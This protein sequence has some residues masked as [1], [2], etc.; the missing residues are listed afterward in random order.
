MPEPNRKLFRKE[1][2]ER[3]SSPDNLERLMPVA[4]ALDWLVI[5]VTGFLLACVVVWSIVGRV[6][7]ITAGRGIILRP[8]QVMQAQTGLGGRILSLRVRAGDHV[9]QGD[10]I[11]TIDQ[12]DIVKRIDEN[13]RNLTNLEEQDKRRTAAAQRQSELQAA[14]DSTERAGLEAQ[15]TALQRS[16]GDATNLRPV[17]QAH[18]ESERNLVKE[19]LVG[20]AAQE[21]ADAA[22]KVRDNEAN[23]QDYTLRLGQI[24]GQL[25]QIETRSGGLSKQILDESL[26]RRNEIDQIRRSIELDEF[27]V[28]EDGRIR[29]EYTGRVAEVMA[30][31]GEVM[32]AGGRLLTLEIENQG[33]GLV[34]ISYFPVRD[35]KKIQPGMQIQITPDTVERERFGGIVGTVTSVSPIPVTK[36]GATSTIGN[37]EVVQS[38]MP[39]GGYIEVRARLQTDPAT[40]SG[41]RWSSSRGPD[42]KITS[43]LTHSTRVTIEGRAP[44]TYF[45]PILREISGVY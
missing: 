35:G 32:P 9:R 27:Q 39:E 19:H 34:S 21:V 10:L 14:Q 2:L 33:D 25:R 29:S 12:S 17:L 38:L 23:I 31:N 45:L 13:R 5:A 3:L 15:R 7:T 11:A 20:F 30:A 18:A 37:A 6:P 43:G 26:A 24:D 44:V 8:R 4:G 41:Y 40:P 22:T 16:L 42:M 28:R 1:A 36:E